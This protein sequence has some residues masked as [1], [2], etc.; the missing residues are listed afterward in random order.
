VPVALLL[1][2][3]VLLL[4]VWRTL[5]IRRDRRPARTRYR[6]VPPDD[7]PDFIRELYLLTRKP[8]PDDEK[9]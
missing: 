4:L 1:L 9:S 8:D 5:A 7:D 3:F 2:A 6:F